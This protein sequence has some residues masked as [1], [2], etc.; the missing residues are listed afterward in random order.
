VREPVADKLDV[1]NLRSGL[2]EE[3]FDIAL[4]GFDR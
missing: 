3:V 2:F 1:A 4:V